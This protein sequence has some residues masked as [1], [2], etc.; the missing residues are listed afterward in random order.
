MAPPENPLRLQITRRFAASRERVFRAFTEKEAV[1][2]WFAGPVNLEWL[3][4]PLLEARAGGRYR[5]TVGDGQRVWC[6]YG[7]YL[8]VKPPERLKFTWLWENEPIRGDSG[9]TVVTV[10][11]LDRGGETE[12]VLTHEGLA[13][14]VARQEHAQGWAECL[15]SIE[16]LVG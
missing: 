1:K 4:E 7:S 5:F 13:S 14:E 12:V 10:E 2:V 16:T 11:F 9:D 8:E 6:I 3:E 15:D